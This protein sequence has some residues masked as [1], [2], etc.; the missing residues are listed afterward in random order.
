MVTVLECMM[1]DLREAGHDDFGEIGELLPAKHAA[2][3]ELVEPK[4]KAQAA[5]YHYQKA[6]EDLIQ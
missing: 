4:L 3:L 2:V 1:L 6:H 5:M